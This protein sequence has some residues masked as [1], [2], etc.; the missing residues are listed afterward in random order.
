MCTLNHLLRSTDRPPTI[1]NVLYRERK[2]GQT[3]QEHS[4]EASVTVGGGS[5]R[6]KRAEL[7]P[8]MMGVRDQGT[9]PEAWIALRAHRAL[10]A[11]L[12]KA[13]RRQRH[14]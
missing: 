5:Q 6:H 12:I 13:P 3:Y 10:R 11:T 2:E 14:P 7:A 1:R 9:Y 8:P 4:H